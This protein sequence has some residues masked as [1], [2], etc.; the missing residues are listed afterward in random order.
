[1]EE[2]QKHFKCDICESQATILCLNCSGY[3]YC[4]SCYKYIHDFKAKSQHKGEKIDYF[5][6]IDAKYLNFNKYYISINYRALLSNVLFY[7]SS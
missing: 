7:E 4:D 3:Y 1:M 6:T 2:K 5:L